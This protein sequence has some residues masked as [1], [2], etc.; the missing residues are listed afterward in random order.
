MFAQALRPAM[1]AIRAIE[2]PVPTLASRQRAVTAFGEL[3]SI[4]VSPAMKLA[5]MVTVSIPMRV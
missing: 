5:M 2:M 4:L 1:M 3:T